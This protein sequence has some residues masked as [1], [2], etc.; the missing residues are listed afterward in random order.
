MHLKPW[1]VAGEAPRGL[2]QKLPRDIDTEVGGGVQD[3]EQQPDLLA[4]PAPKLHEQAVRLRAAGNILCVGLQ[5]S[6]LGAGQ[7]ILRQ[8]T[9]SLEQ[10]RAAPVIEEFWGNVLGLLRESREY[11]LPQIVV[12]RTGMIMELDRS[13]FHRSS[14]SRIP[15][16]CQRSRGKKKLR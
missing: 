8:L 5:D 10:F 16:N 3:I 1:I 13:R 7:I 11:G 12:S 15:M 14:A 4:G 6:G 2:K 9:D